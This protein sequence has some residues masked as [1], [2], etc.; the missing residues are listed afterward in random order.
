MIIYLHVTGVSIVIRGFVIV[1]VKKKITNNIGTAVLQ[2]K[3]IDYII[4]S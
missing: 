2:E 3:R 4:Y 1:K